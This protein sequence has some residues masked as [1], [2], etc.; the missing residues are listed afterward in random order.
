MKD[1]AKTKEQLITELVEIRQ[2]I[3]EVG[4]EE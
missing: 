2:R 3:T 4:L 1:K